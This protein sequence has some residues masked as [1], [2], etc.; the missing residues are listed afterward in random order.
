VRLLLELDA[1]HERTLAAARVVTRAVG[2]DG[3]AAGQYIDVVGGA[4]D[5]AAVLQMHRLKTAALLQACVQ[6]VL[7]LTRPQPEVCDALAT[8]A[9]ELGLMFQIVDDLLDVL[10][11]SAQTGKSPG[12]DDRNGRRT[13]VVD[14]AVDRARQLA[15]ESLARIAAA[16]HD[17]LP[18]ETRELLGIAHLT[19]HRCG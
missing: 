5:E 7:E 4:A 1:P 15:D 13:L 10:A 17:G 14:G 19:R 11:T 9:A 2:T 18:C 8:Y 6:A 12:S 16:L 3:L